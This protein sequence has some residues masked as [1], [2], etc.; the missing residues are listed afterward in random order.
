LENIVMSK[1]SNF[2][3]EDLER[4]RKAAAQAMAPALKYMKHNG[5][6]FMV[7]NNPNTPATNATD[8]SMIA[9]PDL[10]CVVWKRYVTDKKDSRKKIWWRC[11]ATTY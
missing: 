11:A 4:A 1:F 7:Q 5:V 6:D 8:T 3:P 10:A 9:A 2:T